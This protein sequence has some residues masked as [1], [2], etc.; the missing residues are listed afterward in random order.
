MDT[1]R[2]L[3]LY[4]TDPLSCRAVPLSSAALPG[5]YGA[6]VNDCSYRTLG[7]ITFRSYGGHL[8]QEGLL[9]VWV[10]HC[11]NCLSFSR[12]PLQRIH[13]GHR[14]LSPLNKWEQPAELSRTPTS[15]G[16]PSF[17]PLSKFMNVSPSAPVPTLAA[18]Y[19]ALHLSRV[20]LCHQTQYF[21]NIGLGTP[22]QNFTVVF[23]TGSSNFWVPSTR[24]HYFSLACCEFP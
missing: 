10:C 6:A 17:V 24:C 1:G 16:N 14:I 8:S 22:P 19:P 20:L 5:H 3:S 15:D 12:V 2:S 9:D 7:I 23:D 11:L 13:P 21:G 18:E 4:P